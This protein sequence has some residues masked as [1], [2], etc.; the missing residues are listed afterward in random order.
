[1]SH[2]KIGAQVKWAD[3]IQK[4]LECKTEQRK[5]SSSLL[6]QTLYLYEQLL[7][8]HYCHMGIVYF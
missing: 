2:F 1:M 6:Y 8:K 3:K 5:A 7:H 4:K